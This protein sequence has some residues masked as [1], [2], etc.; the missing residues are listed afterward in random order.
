MALPPTSWS[1]MTSTPFGAAADHLGIAK[2]HERGRWRN[3]RAENSHQPTRRRKHKMQGPFAHHR[4][5]GGASNITSAMRARVPGV[6]FS[7]RASREKKPCA[8][9]SQLGTGARACRKERTTNSATWSR[10]D[11]RLLKNI[12][13]N[14]GGPRISIL[15]SSTSSRARASINVSP[16]STPPPGKCQPGT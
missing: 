13:C 11:T 8:A 15:P 3:N 6:V 2:R 16:G 4:S 14:M 5:E 9:I 1:Q 10:C 7:G 12:P